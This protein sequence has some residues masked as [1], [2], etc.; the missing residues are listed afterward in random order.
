VSIAEQLDPYLRTQLEKIRV[1]QQIT[2]PGGLVYT[3]RTDAGQLVDKQLEYTEH[4]DEMPAIVFYTGKNTS[5]LEGDPAPDLGMEN[6]LQEIT[7]EGFIESDKAG[8]EGDDLK[9]DI[10][11][12][13]KADRYWGGLIEAL[14]GFEVDSSTQIGDVVFSVVS[15]KF[16][17][18]YTAP[19][20]SE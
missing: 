8:T 14:Q 13:L 7:V 15:V 1:G 18:L 16:S 19:F 17:A 3:F 9:L 2:L 5:T 6:H 10:A 11:C 12:A 20:G 4:P